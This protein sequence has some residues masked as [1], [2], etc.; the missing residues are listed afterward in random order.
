MRKNTRLTILPL[1]LVILLL[2]GCTQT[3]Q[4]VDDYL[5]TGTDLDVEAKEF[6]PILEALPPYEAIDYRYTQKK[7]FIFEADSVLLNVQYNDETY[8]K[9]KEA[10]KAEEHAGDTFSI[11]S[12]T[13]WLADSDGLPK[14]FGFIG[15]SDEKKAIA[16]LYFYDFD[17][18]NINQSMEAFVTTYFDYDF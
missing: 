2:T 7:M 14:S 5:Q 1:C 13:F 17:L 8:K 3:N 6:M 16:Y 11:N 4:D 18:D 15:T 9:E 12:Y 10:L